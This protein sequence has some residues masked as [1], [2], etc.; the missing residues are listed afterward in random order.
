[1]GTGARVL[2][3]LYRMP[4][5]DDAAPTRLAVANSNS[6]P[7]TTLTFMQTAFDHTFD[8]T[9]FSYWIRVELDR[10]RTNQTVILRSVGIIAD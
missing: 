3:Q 5:F 7:I 2:A 6:S 4:N 9:N 1:V 10:S 8:F